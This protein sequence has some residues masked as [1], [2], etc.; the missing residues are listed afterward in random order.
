MGV[1][2]VGLVAKDA[3]PFPLYL[4]T[5]QNSWVL[6]R[7]ATA[8]LDESHVGRLRSEGVEE[9][10]IRDVDRGVWLDRVESSLDRIMLERDLT[11]ER[12]ALVLHGVAT[13]VTED[14]LRVLPDKATIQRAQ[15]V[16]MATSGLMLREAHGF[17]AIRRVMNASPGLTAHCFTVSVLAMGLAKSVLAADAGTLLQAGLAGLLHDIGKVGHEGLEHDPEHTT[18]GA[19]YLRNL[20]L[21]GPVVEAARLHHERWDGSGYPQALR[22]PAIPQLAHIVGLANTFDNVYSS[23][24]PRVGVFDALRILAQAYHGCFDDKLAQGLVRMFR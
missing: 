20:G 17:H 6:Y 8:E 13:R 19:S 22:G 18:R 3:V 24:Q 14:L 21:P 12:R 16:M 11:L 1:P 10:F 5:A 7:P 9:L 15:K 23:Q 2:L 4:R